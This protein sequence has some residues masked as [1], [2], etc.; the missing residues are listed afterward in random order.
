MTRRDIIHL[1]S[2][3][4]ALSIIS[5]ILSIVQLGV[6]NTAD[7]EEKVRASQGSFYY[8]NKFIPVMKRISGI[9]PHNEAIVMS[10]NSSSLLD[11]FI[12]SKLEIPYGVNSLESLQEYMSKKNIMWLLVYENVSHSISLKPLFGKMGLKKLDNTFQKVFESST[13]DESRFHLYKLR[14]YARD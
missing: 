3:L 5:V 12:D 14:S 4:A 7:F 2:L 13:E 10:F 1:G 9:V 11:Y 8:D 6:S